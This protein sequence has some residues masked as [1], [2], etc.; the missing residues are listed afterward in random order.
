MSLMRWG[1]EEEWKGL[2]EVND[3]IQAHKRI[4]VSHRERNLWHVIISLYWESFSLTVS[5]QTFLK[6]YHTDNNKKKLK[7]T[8]FFIDN[9]N[10]SAWLH[11]DSIIKF[12]GLISHRHQFDYVQWSWRGRMCGVKM[13]WKLVLRENWETKW[14]FHGHFKDNVVIEIEQWLSGLVNKRLGEFLNVR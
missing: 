12:Y 14:L 7:I 5:L 11:D 8:P 2:I 1:W 3:Y 9:V 10:F 4:S 13:F 6:C